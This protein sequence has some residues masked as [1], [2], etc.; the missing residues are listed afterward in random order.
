MNT[1]D[2]IALVAYENRDYVLLFC[3]KAHCATFALAD[4]TTTAANMGRWCDMEGSPD[5]SCVA[6]RPAD[7]AYQHGTP[8]KIRDYTGLK[9][10]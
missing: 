3:S 4:K 9:I 7:V 1:S 6:P 8:P 10:L 5:I 2:S